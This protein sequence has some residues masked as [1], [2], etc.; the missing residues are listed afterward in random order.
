MLDLSVSGPHC[1]KEEAVNVQGSQRPCPDQS[2]AKDRAEKRSSLCPGQITSG[3]RDLTSGLLFLSVNR[4][5][6]PWAHD[7]R[8]RDWESNENANIHL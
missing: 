6:R 7:S 8:E 3:P 2:P 1:L 5:P 4:R